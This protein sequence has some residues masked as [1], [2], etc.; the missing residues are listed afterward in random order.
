MNI[1]MPEEGI[2][3]RSTE[4]HSTDR[5]GLILQFFFW[6]T[7][8][9]IAGSVV[10]GSRKTYKPSEQVR[11]ARFQGPLGMFQVYKQ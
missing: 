10:E 5:Y 11:Q 8:S 6:N 1:Q 9:H 2:G 4:S 7:S 3:M